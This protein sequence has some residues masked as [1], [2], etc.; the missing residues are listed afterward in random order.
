MKQISIADLDDLALGATVLGAGGGGDPAYDLLITKQYL[1]NYQSATLVDINE[2]EEDGLVLPVA[3]MGAPLVCI[4]K[5]PSGL[6]FKAVIKM[7]EELLGKKISYLVAAEVGG[8]NAFTPLMVGAQLGI[9]VIDADTLG[10]LFPN[11]RCQ[12]VT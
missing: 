10:G 11:Y 7:A 12:P 5:L 2:V 1:E 3:F 4:E 9:P 8:G 6:E